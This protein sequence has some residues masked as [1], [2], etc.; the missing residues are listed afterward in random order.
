MIYKTDLNNVF[1]IELYK[2]AKRMELSAQILEQSKIILY[3][4]F[5]RKNGLPV[6]TQKIDGDLKSITLTINGLD[7]V[8]KEGQDFMVNIE[9]VHII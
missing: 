9:S 2:E 3:V 1:K 6:L 5:H 4:E 7:K 8:E